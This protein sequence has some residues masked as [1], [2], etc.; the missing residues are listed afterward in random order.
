MANQRVAT[1]GSGTRREFMKQSTVLAAGLPF[2]PKTLAVASGSG[3][4]PLFD[5]YFEA[6]HGTDPQKVLACFSDDIVVNLWGDGSTLDGKKAAG[7]QWIIPT[8][9][10]YPGNVHHVRNFLEVDDQAVIEWL[11][12]GVDASTHKEAS[13]P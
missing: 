13:D 6:W 12:T 7:D 8:M 1:G 4:R 10:Q 3:L 5:R 9:K 11:F 2:T